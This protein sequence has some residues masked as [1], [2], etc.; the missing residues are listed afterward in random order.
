MLKKKQEVNYRRGRT[1]ADCSQCDHYV[2]DFQVVGIGGTVLG[3]EPRCRIIGLES[4]R[5]YR[6]SPKNWCDRYDNSRH[7][8]RIRGNR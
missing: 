5:M 6:V 1:W 7:M 3:V 4:G 2:P 8:Q